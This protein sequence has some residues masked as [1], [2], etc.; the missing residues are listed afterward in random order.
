VVKKVEIATST[1]Y[2]Y[3]CSFCGQ[4]LSYS[5]N[6]NGEEFAKN[7]E[8]YDCAKN[9]KRKKRKQHQVE[10]GYAVWWATLRCCSCY[11]DFE[12]Q[13]DSRRYLL[14]EHDTLRKCPHCGKR[15]RLDE[16]QCE[17]IDLG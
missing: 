9:P 15:A 2:L 8:I 3:E 1:R 4:A 7:H 5:D 12:V 17:D 16:S 6:R 10:G 11:K 14:I 13:S